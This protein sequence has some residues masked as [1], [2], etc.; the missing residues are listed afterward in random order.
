MS[1][2]EKK[3]IQ[4][5]LETMRDLFNFLPTGEKREDI[6]QIFNR[7]QGLIDNNE[8]G[9]IGYDEFEEDVSG[10][11]YKYFS[12]T[13]AKQRASSGNQITDGQ[14][15]HSTTRPEI[16]GCIPSQDC[17]KVPTDPPRIQEHPGFSEGCVET[18]SSK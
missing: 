15:V 12:S 11:C 9:N 17:D 5:D 6:D 1:S 2:F 3:R 14:G 10:R 8:Y 13:V 18:K 16:G 7:L 4:G